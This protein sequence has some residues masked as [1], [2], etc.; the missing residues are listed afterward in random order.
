MKLVFR[1]QCVLTL[2]SILLIEL[3]AD[4]PQYGPDTL[5][6]HLSYCFLLFNLVA[7]FLFNFKATRGLASGLFGLAAALVL[8][9]AF[10]IITKS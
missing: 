8:F 1:L 9:L 10:E 2:L 5:P 3:Q 7:L 6:I 4:G